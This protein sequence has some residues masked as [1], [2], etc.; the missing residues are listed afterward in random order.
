M[1]N[2]GFLFL[3]LLLLN[4]TEKKPEVK[5][6]NESEKRIDAY[7]NIKECSC[8]SFSIQNINPLSET[9]YRSFNA[10]EYIVS[11][12]DSVF[13]L[14]TLMD[15]EMDKKYDIHYKSSSCSIIISNQ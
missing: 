7:F 4:C 13:S 9:G 3:S 2:W 10:S 11:L 14:D 12:K 8:P 6:I 15:A 1:H 5:I